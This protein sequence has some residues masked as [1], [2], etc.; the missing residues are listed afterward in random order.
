MTRSLGRFS[1]PAIAAIII[2]TV[3]VPGAVQALE[4]YSAAE[5]KH[6]LDWCTGA[7][8]LGNCGS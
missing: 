5:Q 1:G 3:T 8:A 7:K 2:A 6:F 4:T